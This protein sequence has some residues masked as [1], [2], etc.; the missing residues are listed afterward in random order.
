M[1]GNPKLIV[2]IVT[3][4][5]KAGRGIDQATSQFDKFNGAVASMVGPATAVIG[6]IALLGTK[7]IQSASDLQQAAGGVEAVFGDGAKQIEDWAATAATSVGLSAASYSTFASQIGAQFKNLGVPMDQIAGQTDDLIRLGADLA[8][9]YGG[10]TEEAVSALS[11][12]FR[13]EADPAERYG[14][15]LG[16]NAVNAELAARGMDDLEGSALTAAKAQVIMER[17]TKQAGGAV[18]QFERESDTLSGQQQILGATL[19]DTAAAL[20]ES[21][22]PVITPVV[23]ALADFAKWIGENTGLVKVI[24]GI[25][26]ALAVAVIAYTA[27]QWAMNIAMMA[28]P[29]GLVI[30]AVVLLIAAISAL[31][32]WISKNTKQIEKFFK[33]LAKNIQK[34]IGAVAN[35]FKQTWT[36]VTNWFKS[37]FKSVGNF[38]VSIWRNVSNFVKT[39]ANAFVTAWRNATTG[40]RAVVNAV[41]NF[42]SSIWRNV[43]GFVRAYIAGWAT[44]FR[45][46]FNGIRAVV[47]SIASFFANA[48]KNAVNAV[49]GVFR[50]L[51][52]IA[53]SV[54]NAILTPI[55]WVVDAFNNVVGAIQNVIGWLGRIKI[56][57]FGAIG[58]LLGGLA[59]RSASVAVAGAAVGFAAPV[60]SGRALTAAPPPTYYGAGNGGGT[61]INVSGGLDSADTIARRIRQILDARDRR[62]G[63]VQV[64][65]RAKGA[66]P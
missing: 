51:G 44:F 9:T 63:G 2:D 19:E 8:A 58:D 36:Q 5:S 10:T 13:G 27:V 62:T 12:A 3:D 4:A 49:N 31:G 66:R 50:T 38:F 40:V 1:P 22:L 45:N 48:W 34:I 32:I 54:L 7:A 47:G 41:A 29:V 30:A 57:S 59:G 56:P 23:A 60:V 33:D 21:L 55:R 64:V 11:A 37:V 14:L 15:S 65:R 28:N 6:G 46:I 17:A 25:I 20:G 42:F 18:G 53:K 39:I 35:W 43:I 61:V 16:A 26:G 52:N 24:I